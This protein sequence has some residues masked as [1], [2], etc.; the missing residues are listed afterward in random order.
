MNEEGTTD[1]IWQE[2]ALLKVIPGFSSSRTYTR[3]KTRSNCW[4]VL[5]LCGISVWRSAKAL[6]R[7]GSSQQDKRQATTDLRPLVLLHW[8]EMVHEQDLLR[9]AM[10][11]PGCSPVS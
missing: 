10:P 9:S 6:T 1:E 3:L 8:P 7:D 2:R 5:A 4:W 11:S